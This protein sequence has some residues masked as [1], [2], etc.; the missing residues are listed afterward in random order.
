MK[1]RKHITILFLAVLTVF[2]VDA[3]AQSKIKKS[4]MSKNQRESLKAWQKRQDSSKEK[5]LKAG[6][7]S[8]E[9]SKGGLFSSM[10]ANRAKKKD[11]AGM[12]LGLKGSMAK[13]DKATRKRMKRHYRK[14]KKGFRK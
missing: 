6:S 4:Q 12:K 5:E 11:P 14:V 3:Q 1:L 7:S 2:A 13:Q 10:R 8:S 9:S